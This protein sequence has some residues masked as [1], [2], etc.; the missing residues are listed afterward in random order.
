MRPRWGLKTLSAISRVTPSASGRGASVKTDE[1]F[2]IIIIIGFE[3]FAQHKI[4]YLW[5][6]SGLGSLE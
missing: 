6:V 2:L 4:I 3:V 5:H 1:L